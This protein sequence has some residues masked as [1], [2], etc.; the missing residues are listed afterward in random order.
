MARAEEFR[1]VRAT[2]ATSEPHNPPV[3]SNFQTVESRPENTNEV[4]RSEMWRTRS[5]DG[6]GEILVEVLLAG[7]TAGE[8]MVDNGTWDE[9][10]RKRMSELVADM[11]RKKE[12]AACLR[13]D[14]RYRALLKI[15]LWFHVPL[16]VALLVTLVIHVTIVFFYW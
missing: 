12:L 13:R 8:L 6:R 16:T 5:E 4:R 15:W 1:H 7:H 3:Y 2:R 9:D 10:Q 14:C 11:S